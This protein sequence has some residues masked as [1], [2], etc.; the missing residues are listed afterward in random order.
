MWSSTRK[1]RKSG[2]L[3][4]TPMPSS[5]G[6]TTAWP[7]EE[8]GKSSLAPW[9]IPKKSAIGRVIPT[10][11]G[12]YQGR[13]RNLDAGRPRGRGADAFRCSVGG[14]EVWQGALA[15]GVRDESGRGRD[16]AAGVS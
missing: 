14:S 6:T 15:P 1:G 13:G 10:A 16:A 4:R 5:G 7:S 9:R 2:S 3:S 11:F 12:H 8:T